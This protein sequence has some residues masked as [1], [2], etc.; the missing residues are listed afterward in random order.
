MNSG[1]FPQSFNFWV[2][3]GKQHFLTLLFS[4][5][6]KKKKN[7]QKTCIAELRVLD[8]IHVNRLVQ[9]Q[10]HS[11][12]NGTCM[13][14]IIIISLK[15]H[16]FSGFPYPCLDTHSISMI[17]LDGS[18]CF[19]FR[20]VSYWLMKLLLNHPVRLFSGHKWCCF[21]HSVAIE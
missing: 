8:L 13:I 12:I 17:Y 18:F 1:T 20:I 6:L 16:L 15:P 10:A 21:I 19:C 3:L 11:S 14:I 7:Q 4:H 2:I 5:L 9:T